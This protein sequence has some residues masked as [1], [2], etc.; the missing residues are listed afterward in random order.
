MGCLTAPFRLLWTI[1]T[2]VAQLIAVVVAVLLVVIVVTFLWFGEVRL[3]TANL[4]LNKWLNQVAPASS[5]RSPST[6]Y[7]TPIFRFT[8]D[9]DEIVFFGNS[10]SEGEFFDLARQAKQV[11][12]RLVVTEARSVP[13]ET[14][15]HRHKLLDAIGV[16]YERN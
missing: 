14:R 16:S 13:S 11:N 8:W 1:I 6:N 5:G 2:F 12:G 15:D 7:M 4:D 10:I 9:A 3:P